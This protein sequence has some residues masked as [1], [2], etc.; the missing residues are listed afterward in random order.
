MGGATEITQN[1][2]GPRRVNLEVNRSRDL[3]IARSLEL[4]STQYREAYAGGGRRDSRY[5]QGLYMCGCR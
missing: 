5:R 1:Q 3:A 2:V 4:V